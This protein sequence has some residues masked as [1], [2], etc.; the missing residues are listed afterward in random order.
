[1]VRCTGGFGDC[2]G[3]AANGCETDLAA[4]A[5]N[6]GACGRVCALSHASSTCA[7]GACAVTACATGF[8]DCDG[9]AA[10][11]CEVDTRRDNANCG[12][13]GTT[14]A[15]GRVCSAGVCGTTCAPPLSACG[16][17]PATYCANPAIDPA[18]C[19]ACGAV[20]ALDH[21]AT[22]GCAAGACTVVRCAGSYG[23]CDGTAANGC[24]TDLAA[25]VANCGACGRACALPN[26]TATCTAGACAVAACATG[27]LDCDAN[28]ANGCEVDTRSDNANCGTCG[29]TC[30]TGRVCSG[31][32]CG[33]TCAAPL[34]TCGAGPS[35]YCTNTAIDPTDC[36][37]CGVACALAHVAANGCDAS[38]CTVV[39][40]AAGY[41]DCDG[42]AANGCET[43]TQTSA[44]HCGACGRACALPNATSVC[45]AGACAVT[46]CGSGFRDCDGAAANGCEVD[47]RSDNA[48]CGGCGTTCAAGQVCSGGVCG[49]ACASPLRTCGAGPSAYCANPAIDPANCNACGAVC[50]LANVAAQGCAAG[51]CSIVG[52]AAGFAD[53]DGTAANGCETGTRTSAANCGACGRVCALPNAA[54]T[55]TAGACAVA[56]CATGFLDCDLNAANGC[57][58]DTRSDNA[59]CGGCGA[60]CAA[61]RVCSAGVC[62]ATCAAPLTACG[63]GPSAFCANTSVDPANC[64]ACNG[65]CALA[66]AAANGCAA[67][68]C[69][70]VRC[71]AGFGDCDGTASNGCETGTLTSPTHCG[72]CG[73]T[74]ALPNA[75][76]TC[77]A[78]ACAIAAC[79]AGFGDC[80]GLA[81]NGCEANTRTD[82][83][84]CGSCPNACGGS[85]VCAAGACAVTCQ[86]GQTNCSGSC[87]A[88]GSDPLHCG[89]CLT[90]CPVRA[91]AAAYCAGG[92][93]G[94]AC[95]AG[96]GDCDGNAANGCETDLRSSTAHC[97]ACGNRCALSNA[98]ATCVAG[99]CG[100]GSCTVLYA[101]CDGNAANGCEVSTYGNNA[102]CGGCGRACV[103]PQFCS[104]TACSCAAGSHA[105]GTACVPDSA[106]PRPISPLSLGDVT[107]RRPSFYWVLP[108]PYNGADVEIFADRAC[109]VRFAGNSPVT[110]TG[111]NT[112]RPDSDLPA[113]VTA[114]WRVR[115]RIGNASDTV[116]SAVWEFHVPRLS[117]PGID[118]SFNPHVDVNGDGYDDVVVGS[119]SA[120]PAE[121]ENAG[122]VSVFHGGPGGLTAVAARVLTGSQADGNLG[123]SVAGAGDVNGDG[124][125]DLIV[126]ERST[127]NE[128]G[129]FRPTFRV[130]HG[131]AAGIGP[132]PA[133]IVRDDGALFA[134]DTSVACAGDVNG[135]GY[136]DVVVGMSDVSRARVFHGG[137]AGVSTVAAI[138]LL[139]ANPDDL[140]GR[141]VASAGDVNGD[142]YSDLV[143][144]APQAIS[145]SEPARV[146][147]A[148]V[149]HGGV[150]GIT[151][152]P[153]RVIFG[154]ATNNFFGSS[155]ASAGDVNGDGFADLVVGDPFATPLGSPEY[156][157][158]ASVFRGSVGGI[159]A[160]AARVLVGSGTRD[161]FGQSVARAGDVDGD[162]Y[163]DI[164]VGAPGAGAGSASVFRG[165]ASGVE[166]SAVTV[167][168]GGGAWGGHSFGAVV[169][170]GDDVNGDGLADLLVQA[171]QYTVG[172]MITGAVGVF[173]GNQFGIS[174]T[175]AIILAGTRGGDAFGTSVA[176]AV[177]V[178]GYGERPWC[179]LV[180]PRRRRARPRLGG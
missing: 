120:D 20:C 77:A 115:G 107:R 132:Y 7:A 5:T 4:S 112:G 87:V 26:A 14:C 58:V 21:V 89:N 157:G 49:A 60:A 25:S 17:A 162:G 176:S 39:R 146:G 43:S 149:Y 91:N 102:N 179:A 119:P 45:A 135:D 129:S 36:G 79:A 18:N 69:T 73:R 153:A 143:V 122:T 158:T 80:D 127:R 47:T 50:A 6:C 70:V 75:T 29:T 141:S 3:T 90:L 123:V 48:N 85:S 140:F 33:A 106:V 35:A 11:G 131:S 66:H 172:G 65:A 150:G 117:A 57:E 110:V 15:A 133:V 44:A 32:V 175:P 38:A 81:A 180:E 95:L 28:A 156:V 84:H 108:A 1:V 93:C 104:A 142:G 67:G 161:S 37:A 19:N 167:L 165:G 76:A 98:N 54:A 113:G 12:G 178:S 16:T 40:C 169:A 139:R 145:P 101:N 64:G 68:A 99:V 56:T 22:N 78:G 52:C 126:A 31:A 55:C 163:G 86:A 96:F 105:I 53:C 100:L 2:D 109:T 34:R 136:A 171:P 74:C 103:S 51:A 63:A 24:E 92:T 154:D 148:S 147:C 166:A 61:G 170:G 9:A 41:G 42:T 151:A 62:G 114:F 111:G 138:T 137:A 82:N 8:L 116:T 164:L 134:A 130:Y 30:P 59:N 159:A 72:T 46:V 23:D 118:T 173:P 124:Y 83:A 168:R 97:G 13:C 128:F 155:V 177:E 88:L 125:G 152:T 94:S 27:F 174:A 160:V 10:N 121:G 71:A 144:A